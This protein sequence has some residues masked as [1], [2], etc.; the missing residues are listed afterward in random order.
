MLR[1]LKFVIG[2][3]QIL[4]FLHNTKKSPELFWLCL[5]ILM[6]LSTAIGLTPGGSTHLHINNT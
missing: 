3:E 2:A 4:A 5:S 1:T 6:Y